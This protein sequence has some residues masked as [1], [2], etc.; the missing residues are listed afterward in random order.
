VASSI[1]SPLGS[2]SGAQANELMRLA[3]RAGQLRG[4]ASPAATQAASQPAVIIDARTKAIADAVAEVQVK[5]ERV[6]TNK[7]DKWARIAS[8]DHRRQATEDFERAVEST[9]QSI[10]DTKTT[11]SIFENTGEIWL[12]NGY[13][14]M[15]PAV[16]LEY[17]GG[18]QALIDGMREHIPAME[19]ALQSHIEAAKEWRD[20]Y[21]NSVRNILK[22]E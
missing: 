19:R 4:A 1:M 13:G 22:G 3:I 16:N 21:E 2:Q 5:A 20:A 15:E 10:N 17:P 12:R 8:L 11:I 7:S 6:E 18:N 9:I 14:K